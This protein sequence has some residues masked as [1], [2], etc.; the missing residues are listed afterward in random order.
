MDS[1]IDSRIP[2]HPLKATVEKALTEELGSA[3]T[4]LRCTIHG[5][6]AITKWLVVLRRHDGLE[7]VVLVDPGTFDESEFRGRIR[8]AIGRLVPSA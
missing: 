3:R 5:T 8:E 1:E 2:P 7:D 4:P 6:S